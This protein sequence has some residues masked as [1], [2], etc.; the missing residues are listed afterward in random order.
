MEAI[1]LRGTAEENVKTFGLETHT[2]Q[3]LIAY[4]RS[5]CKCVLKHAMF[6]LFKADVNVLAK[7]QG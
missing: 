1:C 6:L 3:L 2:Q 7:A 4:A 5:F